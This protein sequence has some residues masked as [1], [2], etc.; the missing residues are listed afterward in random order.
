M[1]VPHRERKVGGTWTSGR[2]QVE[3]LHRG[4]DGCA[5]GLPIVSNLCLAVLSVDLTQSVLQMIE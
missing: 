1:I 2:P 4:V 5:R 3:V